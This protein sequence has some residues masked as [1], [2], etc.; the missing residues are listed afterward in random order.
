MP[1][2][3]CEVS[4]LITA[5]AGTLCCNWSDKRA[6][7][8]LLRDPSQSDL[9]DSVHA[10][11]KS[12]RLRDKESHWFVLRRPCLVCGR[13]PSDPHHLTFNQPRALGRRVSESRSADLRERSASR[14]RLIGNPTGTRA[15]AHT[16][17]GKLPPSVAR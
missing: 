12:V 5:L 6:V 3:V 16:E 15:A 8:T 11:G 2:Y 4:A 7:Q 1:L 13:V 9:L 17:I 14:N 10:V